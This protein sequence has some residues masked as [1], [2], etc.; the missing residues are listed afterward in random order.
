MLGLVELEFRVKI[1][2]VRARNDL[3]VKFKWFD[4]GRNDVKPPCKKWPRQVGL[5]C[6]LTF[7]VEITAP[8]L[9]NI[10]LPS[11]NQSD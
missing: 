11:R 9:C 6:S 8:V 7:P 4:R 1:I 2:A 5:C 10:I 3:G